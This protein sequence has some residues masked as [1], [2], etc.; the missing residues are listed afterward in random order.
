[1]GC[2]ICGKKMCIEVPDIPKPPQLPD[3]SPSNEKEEDAF[4]FAHGI[5]PPDMRTWIHWHTMVPCGHQVHTMCLWEALQERTGDAASTGTC[6][7]C[8]T[9]CSGMMN[10]WWFGRSV[11]EE[12]EDATRPYDVEGRVAIA[13]AQAC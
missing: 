12:A 5:R 8:E 11:S 2:A 4:L 13:P 10:A 9:P 6:P 3:L 1:M 7:K